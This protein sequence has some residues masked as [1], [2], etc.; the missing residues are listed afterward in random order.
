MED[1][2]ETRLDKT[3]FTV[4]SEFDNSDEKEYWLSRTPEE[5]LLHVEKLRRICYGEEATK[6]MDKSVIEIVRIDWK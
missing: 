6:S 4:M 1:I 5:R 3:K 2:T